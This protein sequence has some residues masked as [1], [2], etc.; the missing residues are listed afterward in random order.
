MSDQQGYGEQQGSGGTPPTPPTPPAPPAPAT[1]PPHA[2]EGQPGPQYD[3]DQAQA[4]AAQGQ[5]Q[6]W[7]AEAQPAGMPAAPPVKSYRGLIIGLVVGLVVALLLACGGVT[8]AFVVFSGSDD[9]RRPATPSPSV[10]TEATAAPSPAAPSLAAAGPGVSV[11][12]APCDVAESIAATARLTQVQT[13]PSTNT[14]SDGNAL[15]IELQ[16]QL[17]SE[18][19]PFGVTLHQPV[20][21]AGVSKQYALEKQYRT[22]AV[23][24]DVLEPVRGVG[25]EG[26]LTVKRNASG[27][28]SVAVV[29]RTE[30]RVV[31]VLG[32][33]NENYS[34]AKTKTLLIDLAKAYL[35]AP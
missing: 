15:E 20:G 25:T 30:T 13:Q 16:C 32:Q 1:P 31:A 33:A 23:E 35:A 12:L 18:E 14:R 29:A 5:P 6:G 27:G 9:A 22:D 21:T 2:P 7:P 26:I 4:W 34:E 8:A 3:S 10:R 19:I 17:N 11:V 24:L 28:A